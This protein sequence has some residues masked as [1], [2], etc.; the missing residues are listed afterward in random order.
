MKVM[1]IY[2]TFQLTQAEEEN[3]DEIYEP[4]FLSSFAYKAVVSTINI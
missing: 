4:E 1:V 2:N 3:N